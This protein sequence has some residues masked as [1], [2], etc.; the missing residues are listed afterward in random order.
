MSLLSQKVNEKFNFRG[1]VHLYFNYKILFKGLFLTMS[2]KQN[3][4]YYLAIR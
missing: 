3:M 1:N 2:Q 4:G